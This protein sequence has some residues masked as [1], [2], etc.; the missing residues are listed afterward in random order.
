MRT[1]T[2]NRNRFYRQKRSTL[3][4]PLEIGKKW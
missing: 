4:E 2:E 3:Q 1:E